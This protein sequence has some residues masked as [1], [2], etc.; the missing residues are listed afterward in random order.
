[1]FGRAP[2][3]RGSPFFERFGLPNLVC[4]GN[5]EVSYA[6]P[7]D[8]GPAGIAYR[9]VDRTARELAETNP[10]D[11][12]LWRRIM[13]PLVAAADTVRHIG[14]SDMRSVPESMANPKGL[15]GAVTVAARALELGTR[16]WDRL[17]EAERSGA[18]LTG[19][20]AHANT[21]LPSLAGAG[22]ALLLGTLAHSHGWPI[23]TGGSQAI[24]N[25]LLTD[26]HAHGVTITC[27]CRID[28]AA[29]L[30][31]AQVYLFDTSPWTLASVF[32]DRLSRHY[33]RALERFRPGNGVAKVDFALS[34]PVPWA[35]PRVASAG[36][37][38]LGG[39]P[40]QM[41]QAEADTTAGRHS[42]TPVILLS[43]PTV[44]DPTRFGPQ[45]ERP[46]WTYA[47]VPNGSTSDMTATVIRQVERFAPG[48]RDVIIGTRCISAS[49][50]ARHNANYRGGDI[51][52]GRVSMY[53]MAAR[54]VAKWDPYRTSID[55][56]YLCSGSTPPGPG[57]HGMSGLHAA[58]RVLRQ[59]FGVRSLPDLT[60]SAQPV[61]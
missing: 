37:V 57:V 45:G 35:D 6:H 47:H 24:T 43:Q 21:S 51:A 31:P 9:S 27:D 29:A 23:P 60:A 5:P 28:S 52:V 36:T 46:L 7:L 40:A 38:H 10:A 54:P 41:A 1:M 16:L 48:F 22:T 55:N 44:V 8:D 33:R 25:A 20:G 2:H 56:V 32:G 3:G 59:H 50:M 19:V 17:T 49:D 12:R 42:A 13:D 30:P 15:L 39:S 53:R 11:G 14:L 58:T 18:M 61:A 26:L 34:P 4:F